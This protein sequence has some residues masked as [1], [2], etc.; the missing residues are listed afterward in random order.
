MNS[1]SCTPFEFTNFLYVKCERERVLT[2]E[3][4]TQVESVRAELDA[5]RLKSQAYE[6]VLLAREPARDTV[7]DDSLHIDDDLARALDQ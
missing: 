6:A 2:A 7:P 3:L 4:R 1:F 5:S